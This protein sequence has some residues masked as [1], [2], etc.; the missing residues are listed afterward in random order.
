MNSSGEWVAS[1]LG[2]SA[3][4]I[5][6]GEVD[7]W[8]WTP[9][10]ALLPDVQIGEIPALAGAGNDPDRAHFAHYDANGNLI[11]QTTKYP[12]GEV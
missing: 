11:E 12:Y 2:G 6:P 4:K 8:S 9:D 10:E 7:G 1:P 3:T 5:A